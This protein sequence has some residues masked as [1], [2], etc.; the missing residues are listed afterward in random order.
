M[1]GRGH[2]PH[3]GR[4]PSLIVRGGPVERRSQKQTAS[5]SVPFYGL[6]AA[7][8]RSFEYNLVA[9]RLSY[10]TAVLPGVGM[11]WK[12]TLFRFFNWAKSDALLLPPSHRNDNEKQL[13]ELS[14]NTITK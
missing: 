13:R 4:M 12:F 6:L 5:V 7:G 14:L 2:F 9:S 8:G 3:L 1:R 10:R 11:E